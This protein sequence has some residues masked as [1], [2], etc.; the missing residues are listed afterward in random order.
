LTLFPA[1]SNP[2]T[3]FGSYSS[4]G[5]T[6]VQGTVLTVASDRTIV[7]AGTIDGRMDASGT[8]TATTNR[9]ISVNGGLNVGTGAW[10]RLGTGSSVRVNDLTSGVGGG[11]L[12]GGT[13][14]VGHRFRQVHPERRIL[15]FPKRRLLGLHAQWQRNV[16]RHRRQSL[17]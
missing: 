9:S 10:A 12:S 14:I 16:R 8:I 5:F 17:Q 7:G 6:H 15:I 4:T 3:F 2:A 1:G 11:S 13:L